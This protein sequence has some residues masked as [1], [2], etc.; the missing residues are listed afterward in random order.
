M[1]RKKL[2]SQSVV[3]GQVF[4]VSNVIYS[5]AS[6]PLALSYLTVA[7]F[8]L[9]AVVMQVA[10]FLLLLD[11]G[12]SSGAGRLLIDVKDNRPSKVYGRLVVSTFVILLC[13]GIVA[14]LL[15]LAIADSLVRW[16]RIPSS[17]SEA[18]VTLI[19][20]QVIIAGLTLPARTIGGCLVAHGRIDLLNI[21]FSV[22]TFASLAAMWAAF[23]A[24]AGIYSLLWANGVSAIY[25]V[26]ATIAYASKRG[27]LPA[28]AEIGHPAW[29]DF[30]KVLHL[31]H[32]I[33]LNQIGGMILNVSQAIL[34][35]RFAGLETV[36]VWSVGSK[37]YQLILQATDKLAQSAGPICAEMWAR[38]EISRFNHRAGQLKRLTLLAGSMG[39]ALLIAF[40]SQFIFTWT[41][42]RVAWSAPYNYL[43]ALLFVVRSFTTMESVPIIASKAYK[44]YRFIP[45]AEAA[46]FVSLA[47]M[48]IPSLGITGLLLSALAAAMSITLP[49]VIYRER[50]RVGMEGYGKGF[51]LF[52][53]IAGCLPVASAWWTARVAKPEMDSWVA[54]CATAAIILVSCVPI[55]WMT[56]R[57]FPR[58]S[59][60]A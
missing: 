26:A 9:W 48:L 47:A 41:N 23:R 36:G 27:F 40:N 28:R 12:F 20:G 19:A 46:A 30:T 1:D 14:L 53:L 8:G 32:N 24:G 7:E 45:L 39:A 60:Q 16:M 56:W 58:R 38:G 4:L 54:A 29:A 13:S 15:G 5:L 49:Y 22:A 44:S 34:L 35:G 25:T 37:L 51:S 55:L 52:V 2:F 3:A 11:A 17:L 42:D 21:A 10:N 57:S 31:S 33:F 43:L 18:A 6:I 59:A 50:R